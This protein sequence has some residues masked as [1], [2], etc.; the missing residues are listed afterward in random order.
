[1]SDHDRPIRVM[2]VITRMITGGAQ[3]VVRQLLEGLP[4]EQVLVCG[5]DGDWI[6]RNQAVHR[7]PSLQRETRPGSDAR[8]VAELYS[9]MRRWRPTVVHAHTYKAGVVGCM[10]ARLAGIRAVI[11]TPHGHIF[12]SGA[13]IPGVPRGKKLEALRWVTRV[14]QLLAHHVTALSDEDLLQQTD[15]R[16]APRAKYSV[17]RNGISMNGFTPEVSGK[18]KW[19][20]QNCRPL[21]GTVGRLTRE[22]G[23]ELLLRAMPL[24]RRELPEA[25][26]A[27][28]GSGEEEANLRSIAGEGVHML[29]AVESHEI[30]PSFDMYV[31]PSHYESQ[32]LAILEAMA[33]YRPVVATDVGGVRDVVH[34]GKTGLLVRKGDAESFAAAVV[35]LVRDPERARRFSEEGQRRV[36]REFSLRS[37]LEAYSSLYRS[38]LL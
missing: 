3:K 30:L 31:H 24:I 11:F 32:G 7:V 27:I 34:H 10:A 14:S 2:Q 33:A 23:H 35:G 1:M 6:P 8:A 5:P 9:L 36:S 17:I 12:A 18:E 28:V 16:L 13:Q 20:L 29:G 19:G 4:Y 37:M 26:L 21:L 22:K 38:L 15:L 25:G